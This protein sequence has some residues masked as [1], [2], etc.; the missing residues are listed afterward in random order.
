MTYIVMGLGTVDRVAKDSNEF[1]AL[2][3]WEKRT[4]VCC[5]L[6]IVNVVWCGLSGDAELGDLIDVCMFILSSGAKR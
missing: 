5:C 1:D 6:G 3:G 4:D 2:T